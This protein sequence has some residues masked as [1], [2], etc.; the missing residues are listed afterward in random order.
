MAIS[1]EE[2]LHVARLAR[3][4]LSEDAIAR[5]TRPP[6]MS[7][8]CR[9]YSVKTERGTVTKLEAAW[10]LASLCG[11]WATWDAAAPFGGIVAVTI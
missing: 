10:R 3:L 11:P 7:D 6:A 2:V 9:D 1:R 5:R 8:L 4:E